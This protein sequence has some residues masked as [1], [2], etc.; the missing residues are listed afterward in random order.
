MA[1]PRNRHYSQRLLFSC[2]GT[3]KMHRVLETLPQWENYFSALSDSQL[4]SA[5]EIWGRQSEH[6]TS[7]TLIN[8][9]IAVNSEITFRNL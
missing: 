9:W 7:E 1:R 3:L 5:W 2:E 4:L 6:E 8:A